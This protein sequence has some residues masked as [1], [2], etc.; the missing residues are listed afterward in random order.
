MAESALEK[1][2]SLLR[3]LFQFEHRDLNFGIYRIMNLRRTQMEKWINE[4]LPKRAEAALKT[5]AISVESELASRL[6][7]LRQKL[8]AVQADAVDPDGRLVKLQESDLGKEYQQKWEQRSAIANVFNACMSILR[9][10]HKQAASSTRTLIN[11]P[12]GC[13]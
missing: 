9:T 11:I 4:E 10:T 8:T 7:E 6:A 1:F 13:R 2:Q 12:A 5:Q 3:E